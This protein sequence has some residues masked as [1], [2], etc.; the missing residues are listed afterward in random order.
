MMANQHPG[1]SL[2]EKRTF[3]HIIEF[4]TR[5][6]WERKALCISAT[7]IH[8]SR[9]CDAIF[10]FLLAVKLHLIPSP[11]FQVG[12]QL[13][14]SQEGRLPH[15]RLQPKTALTRAVYP[16]L[17]LPELMPTKPK[18]KCQTLWTLPQYILRAALSTLVRDLPRLPPLKINVP[19][20]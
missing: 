3:P 2:W 13:F 1:V 17:G 5:S 9:Q 16:S 20:S 15:Q 6:R 4:C 18:R 12:L 11:G 7:H 10:P 19:S 8:S 14:W